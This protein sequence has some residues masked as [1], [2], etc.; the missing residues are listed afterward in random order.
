MMIVIIETR[1]NENSN[2]IVP[3][4]CPA[5]RF[6]PIYSWALRT[7][8]ETLRPVQELRA[9][10]RGVLGFGGSGLNVRARDSQGL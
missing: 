7:T 9:H 6:C 5:R 2:A 1:N 10:G 8:L 3:P 4:S